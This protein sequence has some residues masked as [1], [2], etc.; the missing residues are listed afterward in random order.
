MPKPKIP[1]SERF[2]RF[3]HKNEDGCWIW[4]GAKTQKGDGNCYPWFTISHHNGVLAHRW[5]YMQTKGGIP[6]G[7]QIDHLCRVTLCVN[8]DH[9]EAVT[10]KENQ[11]RGLNGILRPEY[12]FCKKG[13]EQTA[14]TRKFNS[15]NGRSSCR[16]CGNES[17]RAWM[18]KRYASEPEFRR[19]RLD[20]NKADYYRY[21]ELKT[22]PQTSRP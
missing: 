9:L 5:S 6:E 20:R 16:I 21:K 8:P 7:Y 15:S 13:H 18:K 10:P 14:E 11:A 19:Q 2:Q 17:H 12:K 4:T 22:N 1:A 3:I